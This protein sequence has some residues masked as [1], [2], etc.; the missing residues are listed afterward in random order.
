M[1]S[2]VLP[3][4]RVGVSGPVKV[5]DWLRGV[6]GGMGNIAALV[7]V[8]SL[9]STES[10]G[11]DIVGIGG[12]LVGGEDSGGAAP[13]RFLLWAAV[14]IRPRVAVVSSRAFSVS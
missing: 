3:V 12:G 8:G 1:G 4:S 5:A 11:A 2:G 14:G 10:I 6:A 13:R 9:S 7:G